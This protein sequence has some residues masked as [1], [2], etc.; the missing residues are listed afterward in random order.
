MPISFNDGIMVFAPKGEREGDESA[1][2]REAIDTRPLS[3]KS[4]DNKLVCGVMNFKCRGPLAR[5]A[6]PL[7]RGFV[8]GRQLLANVVDL[9][10]YGR[11]SCW[12]LPPVASQLVCCCS[13]SLCTRLTLR[14]WGVSALPLRRVGWRS[15]RLSLVW[16][17][18][19]YLAGPLLMV[20]LQ[21][22]SRERQR[23]CSRLR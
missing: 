8:P 20:D 4:S 2:Y 13:S 17:P 15:S 1:M 22:S 11:G 3:L 7:Q 21:C 18:V 9:D 10:A 14:C 19:R 12:S 5:G 23:R 6:C 16:L